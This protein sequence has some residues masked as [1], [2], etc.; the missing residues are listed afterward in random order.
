MYVCKDDPKDG[1]THCASDQDKAFEKSLDA[2]RNS[3]NGDVARAAGA[4]GAANDANGV[5]VGFADLGKAG[6]GGVTRSTLGA[7]ANG[8]LFAQSDVTINSGSTGTALSADIGHEGSH[9]ADAQDMVKGI[10]ITGGGTGFTV[11][12]DISQYASEQRAYR[13]TDSIYRSA[14]EP[15][16][17]CGMPTVHLGPGQARLVSAAESTKSCSQIPSSTI[18]PMGGP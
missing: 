15:Y 14:N 4:Y 8:K 17:G 12:V 13:V 3:K 5:T 18:Q 2:L 6:E 7:D 11:G 9:V 10:T 1:S 16:N